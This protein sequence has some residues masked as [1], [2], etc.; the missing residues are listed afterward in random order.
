M[1]EVAF[2]IA[3]DGNNISFEKER[4]KQ[5]GCLGILFRGGVVGAYRKGRLKNY[6]KK[7][8]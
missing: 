7:G 5:H 3:G 8:M 6:G 1:I 2:A 4:M